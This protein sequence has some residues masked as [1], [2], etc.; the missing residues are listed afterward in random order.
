MAHS[1]ANLIVTILIVSFASQALAGFM[2]GASTFAPA[3]AAIVAK[4][5][6]AKP[7]FSQDVVAYDSVGSGTGI[8]G[9]NSGTYLIAVSDDP[10]TAA[11]EGAGF[12]ASPGKITVPLCVSTFGFFYN[13]KPGLVLTATQS[14]QIY[15]GTIATWAGVAGAS[16]KGLTGA[17]TRVARSD[18]SGSTAIVKTM[19]S[20]A[21]TGFSGATDGVALTFD[22]LSKVEGTSAVCAAV[23]ATKGAIGYAFTGGCSTVYNKRNPNLKN[24]VIASLKNANGVA[25]AP[26]SWSPGSALTGSPPAADGSWAAVDFIWKAGAKTPPMVSME[27]AFIRKSLTGVTGGKI[28]KAFMQYMIG[29]FAKGGYGFSAT[30]AA[31]K[32]KSITMVNA[33]A[34]DK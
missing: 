31:W 13:G 18:K 32:S 27:F 10:M 20:K 7:G 19:W 29:S 3:G 8:T 33:I 4:W 2:G 21:A 28:A 34:A 23:L 11:Q 1:S 16:A 17:I 15:S 30:P 25:V 26:P 14:Y 24:R 5:N 9:F 22:G 12:S 6:K